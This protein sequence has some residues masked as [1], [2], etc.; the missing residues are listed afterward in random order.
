[1][2]T[3][4]DQ[5]K[6]IKQQEI[7]EK[8][9][10]VSHLFSQTALEQRPAQISFKKSL[11][12]HTD[13][14]LSLIAEV[15]AKAPGRQNVE[16]LDVAQVLKDYTL[17]G[18]N[19]I[20]V[21]T[22]GHYFGG[23]L[24]VMDQAR[25]LTSLPLLHKEFIIDPCQLEEGCLRGANAALI[26]V[27]YFNESALKTMIKTCHD[28][29][30]DAVVECSLE[31]ELP[32]A[33]SVNPDILLINNRPIASIPANP[34]R[35]YH[36]GSVDVSLNW[37]E[38]HQELRE[39]KAQE[40]KVLISASCISRQE[41]M[42]RIAQLPFDAVLIGNSVMSAPDRVHFLKELKQAGFKA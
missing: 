22:D 2:E 17:A 30:M 23:S 39:W 32:R 35:Q 34:T 9:S 36:E 31:S 16:T 11:E 24:E 26:L 18:V 25:S 29:G 8:K 41:D 5:M 27:Y 20:S 42:R 12:R 13:Q 15:K 7:A 6:A 14:G 3:F 10:S 21:L 37:W 40:H 28:L 33:L 1:M 4:L 19:A 38:K